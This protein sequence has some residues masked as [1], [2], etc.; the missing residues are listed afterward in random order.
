MK[1]QLHSPDVGPIAI[2]AISPHVWVWVKRLSSEHASRVVVEWLWH[3]FGIRGDSSFLLLL[4]LESCLFGGALAVALLLFT[5][6]SWRR[7]A[8]VF[9]VAF[10]GSFYIPSVL[11]APVTTNDFSILLFS[12]PAVL[13]LL[14]C[15]VAMFAVLS[16]AWRQ[17]AA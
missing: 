8:V 16:K 15:A 9:C 5:K 11:V 1:I 14:F 12:L 6:G 7:C 4:A 10:V 3:V 2:G 13:A 17:N